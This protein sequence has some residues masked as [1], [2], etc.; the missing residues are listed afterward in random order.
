LRCIASPAA[1]LF[2]GS[3]LERQLAGEKLE[4]GTQAID[5]DPETDDVQALIATWLD[6]KGSCC[7]PMFGVV[8]R[9]SLRRKD[10]IFG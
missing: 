1:W 8:R 9:N 3:I 6:V 7:Y 2:G 10:R 5:V 4:P